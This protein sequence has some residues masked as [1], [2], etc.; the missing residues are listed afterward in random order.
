MQL[1]VQDGGVVAE[2]VLATVVLREALDL[3]LRQRNRMANPG[4]CA[5]DATAPASTALR[6][7]SPR[8]NSCRQFRPR[9][10][11]ENTKPVTPPHRRP[12]RG[13]PGLRVQTGWPQAARTGAAG[14]NVPGGGESWGGRGLLALTDGVLTLYNFLSLFLFVFFSHSAINSGTCTSLA[15]SQ[16]L[17][18]AG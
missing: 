8:R 17:L 18:L 16:E 12:V 10:W 3:P 14:S 4:I 1:A 15:G 5:V 11:I 9:P 13:A 7:T 2:D 6:P